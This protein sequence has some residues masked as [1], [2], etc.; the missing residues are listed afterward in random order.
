MLASDRELPVS[1]GPEKRAYV[2]EI[3]TA[4][5]PTYDRLNRIISLRLRSALAAVRGADD[6][7]GSGGRTESTS[8]SA[9]ARSI[10]RP[11]LAT[12]ARIP[13]PD[14]RRRLR[15]GHAPARARKGDRAWRRSRPTRSSCRSR[16]RAFDGA[17]VGWGM[18]NLVD[19]DAGL[20][21]AARVL[22]PGGR[23]VIL[24]MTLPPRPALRRLYQFY[25]R[26]VLPWVGRLISKHT[27]AYTWLPESTHRVP[28]P[29]RVR[30]AARARRVSTSVVSPVHGRGVRAARGDARRGA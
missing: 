24:E 25:F 3:F 23:L 2:R 10:S 17:M 6:W 11:T 26:R 8:T 16:M 12:P 9:P 22:R 7:A 19:L 27:T 14:R 18:R 30:A 21:E 1:G 15:P 20:A 28:E 13:G 5:A 29:G 4:I